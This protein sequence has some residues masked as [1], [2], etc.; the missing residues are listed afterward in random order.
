MAYLVDQAPRVVPAQELIDKIQEYEIETW[1]AKRLV[2]QYI[3]RL[4]QK[5]YEA[6]GRDNVISTIRGIG[7]SVNEKVL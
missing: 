6:T 5:I 7:Y 4:R 3:Y 1:E 2:R